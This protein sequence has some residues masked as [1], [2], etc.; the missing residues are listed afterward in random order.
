MLQELQPKTLAMQLNRG[1]DAALRMAL[2]NYLEA[3]GDSHGPVPMEVGAMKGK[4]GD[5]GKKG[6]GK[7]FGK[8]DK[9]NEY[10]KNNE[11]GKGSEKRKRK[12]KERQRKRTRKRREASIQIRVSR[13]TAGHAARVSTRRASVGK[14]TCKP[15]RFRV[16]PRVQWRRVQRTHLGLRRQQ[17]LFKRSMTRVNRDGSSA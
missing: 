2:M 4:K 13:A 10:S 8:Y 16:L 15:W 14:V 7:S 6:Y 9:N 1:D 5:K 17:R 3:E 11:Y 12:R